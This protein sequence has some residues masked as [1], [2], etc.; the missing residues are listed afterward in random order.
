MYR[1]EAQ[2]NFRLLPGDS[3]E[4][5]PEYVREV[6]DDPEIEIVTNPWNNIPPVA[7][8]TAAG[9]AVIRDA[10]TLAYPRAVVT[11][12]LP[13]LALGGGPQAVYCAPRR[14]GPETSCKPQHSYWRRP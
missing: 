6:V 2:V 3:Q 12:P 1:A 7:S 8:H 9:F 13:T 11:P 5:V 14:S 10:V 4:S